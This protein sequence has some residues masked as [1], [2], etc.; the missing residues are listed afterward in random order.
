MYAARRLTEVSG[1]ILVG[2]LALPACGDNRIAFNTPEP[3]P[4]GDLRGDGAAGPDAGTPLDVPLPDFCQGAGQVVVIGGANQC[5]GDVAQEAFQ[6]GLCACDTVAG[7]Q[8]QLLVDA[9]D[10][11]E[12]PYTP[13]TRIDDGHLGVNGA[14]VIEG[15]LEVYGSLF[16]SGGGLAVGPNSQITGNAYAA[17]TATQAMSSSEIGGN[18][19]FDGD[20]VG[21]FE[22]GG[23]LHVPA[24]AQVAPQTENAVGGEIVRGPVSGTP[25]CACGPGEVLD[26]GA[27]TAWAETHNDNDVERVLTATTWQDGLGPNRIDLPCGRYYLTS[28]DHPRSL[29]IRAEGRTVLFVDGDMIVRGGVNLET[30]DDSEIDLFVA[31]DLSVGAVARFGDER[32]PSRVRTYVGG[33]GDIEF[34]ASSEFGGNLYAPRAAVSFGASA[35]LFGSL[36]CRTARFTGNAEVHFDRAVRNLGEE[37]EGP[38]EE[39]DAGPPADAGATGAACR[40]CG[41]CRPNQGCVVPP[42]EETGVC[43][44]CQDDLDCCAPRSCVEGRCVLNP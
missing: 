30:T 29:T 41:D 22:I 25:P 31:G 7:V 2:A 8:S 19:F 28:I 33:D 5:V 37:C 35:D 4:D 26:V 3:D 21:R 20:V 17:G 12:G 34:N 11:T 14:L 40:M 1:L 23:N 15:R 18:A 6:F 38:T 32:R 10:S 24:A 9:F 13:A 39:T 44:A 27:L 42:D 36:V 43:G 16:A